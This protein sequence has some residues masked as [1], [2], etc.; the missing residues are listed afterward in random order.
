MARPLE[1]K[2]LRRP[3]RGPYRT[4]G[5]GGIARRNSKLHSMDE[6]KWKGGPMMAE[7]FTR[8]RGV[9]G[10]AYG[11]PLMPPSLP[12]H[13]Y[14]NREVGDHVEGGKEGWH[15]ECQR[16]P[17]ATRRPFLLQQQAM[18]GRTSFDRSGIGRARALCHLRFPFSLSLNSLN[19]C[20]SRHESISQVQRSSAVVRPRQQQS[21]AAPESDVGRS[22]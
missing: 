15:V 12:L 3:G 9:D 6:S 11:R 8:T 7:C 16:F 5:G 13:R 2:R 22:S 19:C 1:E 20:A 4:G 18:Y 14:L 17:S 21:T 10:D